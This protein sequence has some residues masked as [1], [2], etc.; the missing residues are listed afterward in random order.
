[1][2]AP[3]ELW[4][5]WATPQLLPHRVRKSRNARVRLG[6]G[7]IAVPAPHGAAVQAA[8]FPEKV[9]RVAAALL[10]F[11]KPSSWRLEIPLPLR[12]IG[13]SAAG[14]RSAHARITPQVVAALL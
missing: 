8:P 4:S 3:A 14:S 7:N 12:G 5:D 6:T 11:V 2:R 9:V 1:M 10:P 13:I